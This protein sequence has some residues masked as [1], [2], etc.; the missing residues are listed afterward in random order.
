MSIK[1]YIQKKKDPEGYLQKRAHE[2]L[3]EIEDILAKTRTDSIEVDTFKTE[4]AALLAE[5]E[6]AKPELFDSLRAYILENIPEPLKGDKG[7]SYILTE[8]D[9]ATIAAAITVPVVDKIIEKTEVIH[10]QPIIH[11]VA[12]PEEITAESIVTRLNTTTE[13]VDQTVIKGLVE[14]LAL[15]KREVRKKAEK[16]GATG[17]GMGQVQH[18]TKDVSS[19]TTTVTTDYKIAGNGY[20]IM[21][22]YYQSALIMRGEHY[23]VGGDRKTLTLLFTPQ[24]STKIDIIYVRG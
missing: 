12:V 14:E 22:A 18:E 13:S 6:A 17:G 10:E 4:F 11:E 3:R 8:E 16:G 23:T 9:K 5:L 24:D 20:A 19:A 21:G 7:D 2:I 1:D 15:L